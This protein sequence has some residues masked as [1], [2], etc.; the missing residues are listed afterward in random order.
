MQSPL[1]TAHSESPRL[2]RGYLSVW[3]AMAGISVAYLTVT[4]FEPAATTRSQATAPGDTTHAIEA[5]E[6]RA[7]RFK[8]TLEDFQRDLALLR[9]SPEARALDKGFGARLAALEERLS[10]ETGIA[11]ADVA[12]ATTPV[13]AAAPESAKP[14]VAKAEAARAPE[15][16][17]PAAKPNGPRVAG[18]LAT[19]NDGQ[20]RISIPPAAVL[21]PQPQP[22]SSP[23]ETGSLQKAPAKLETPAAEAARV[24][25][26]PAGKPIVLNAGPAAVGTAVEPQ[27]K[28]PAPAQ[29]TGFAAVVTTVPAAAPPPPK[30]YAV[31][32]GS[33]V[34]VDELRL[35]WSMLTE[36]HGDALRN[37]Q[38]R[39]SQTTTP[40]AGPIYDLS[41]GP[42]RSA[43]DAKK[44]CKALAARG[45]DCKVANFGG[46]AL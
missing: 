38:P 27:P 43:A 28:Q 29:P 13:V 42:F 22:P 3:A 9:D 44:A 4:A 5:A 7:I 8:S 37:L 17:Q 32:L 41:A 16:V 15:P 20:T 34:S 40:E 11:V 33:A 21:Q 19:I 35:S 45:V 18:A 24:V 26:P 25:A 12:S 23:I 39:V 36:R 31:Q 14:E 10:I 6:A 2:P 1:T 30:P 46:D